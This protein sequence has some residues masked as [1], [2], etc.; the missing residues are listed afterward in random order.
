MVKS[1]KKSDANI[2]KIL[3]IVGLAIVALGVI[4]NIYSIN[5]NLSFI[6]SVLDAGYYCRYI[7]LLLGGYATGYIATKGNRNDKLFGGTLYILIAWTL[8][9]LLDLARRLIHAPFDYLGYPLEAIIFGGQAFFALCITII[10]GFAARR[11]KRRDLTKIWKILFA[12]AYVLYTL[13]SLCDALL[14]IFDSYSSTETLPPWLLVSFLASPIVWATATYALLPRVDDRVNRIFYAIAV[15][16]LA[17]IFQLVAWEFQN[18]P[19]LDATNRMAAIIIALSFA[20]SIA[21]IAVLR[22]ASK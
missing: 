8:F 16:A 7:I 1:T 21:L 13:Y 6:H 11:S 12:A 17:G 22:K 20:L 15:P 14:T 10:L 3:G 2:T 9:L 4:A 5:K 18:E 19:T